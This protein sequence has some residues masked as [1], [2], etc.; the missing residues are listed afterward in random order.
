M[1]RS[2]EVEPLLAV[3]ISADYPGRPGVLDGVR[4]RCERGEI[5]GLIGASGS[6]KSTL[7]L[8]V[9]RLLELRG[10]TIRGSI[11]F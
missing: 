10:G 3:N 5:A 8:A 1:D 6:G 11:R 9:L 2:R 4:S 7:A